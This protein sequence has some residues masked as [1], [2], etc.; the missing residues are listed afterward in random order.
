MTFC[1][2][3]GAEVVESAKFC[4][5]C[6]AKLKGEATAMNRFQEHDQENSKSPQPSDELLDKVEEI[7]ALKEKV[8]RKDRWLASSHG[9]H[10]RSGRLPGGATQYM[11]GGGKSVPNLVFVREVDGTRESGS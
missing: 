4:T 9:L 3:C 2:N 11:V 5:E 7:W 10:V 1:P 8:P 6:G